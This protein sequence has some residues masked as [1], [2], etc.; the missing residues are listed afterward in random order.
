MIMVLFL[1][2]KKSEYRDTKAIN[3]FTTTLWVFLV[4][5]HANGKIIFIIYCTIFQQELIMHNAFVM[6]ENNAFSLLESEGSLLTI[7]NN[8]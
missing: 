7:F 2:P 5:V 8:S 6:K 3:C 1:P 4:L